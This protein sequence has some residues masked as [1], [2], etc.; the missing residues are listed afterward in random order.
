MPVFIWNDSFCVNNVTIDSHH[1][2]LFRIFNDLYN[3]TFDADAPD[4][5]SHIL[6][7]LDAY[8]KYHFQIEEQYMRDV[9]HIDTERHVCMHSYFISRVADINIRAGNG[10]L[11]VCRE[12]IFFLG[13]WLKHHVVEE[14]R[15]IPV[16]SERG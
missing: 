2:E 13:N 11:D 15:R 6:D 10:S 7:E 8:A 14:D 3:S 1:K 12:L 16:E 9:R 4:T 5:F